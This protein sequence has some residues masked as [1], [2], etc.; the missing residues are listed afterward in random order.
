MIKIEGLFK[1]V[2]IKSINGNKVL[3]LSNSEKDKNGKFN[4]TYYQVWLSDKVSNMV[5]NELKHKMAN[6]AMIN[7]EG[8]LK[9]LKKD[10]YTNLTIYPSKITEYKKN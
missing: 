5:D 7:V 9:V 6:K 1:C 4:N 10:K 2:D 3:N 8:W